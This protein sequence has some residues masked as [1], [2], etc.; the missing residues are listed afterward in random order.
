MTADRPKI[1]LALSGGS[2]RAI[3][4]IGVL[5]VFEE[6]GIPIDFLTACSSGA[7]I[8]ASFACGTIGDLKRDWLKLNRR[9]LIELLSLEKEGG[10][11]FNIDKFTNWFQRYTLGK[12][13]EDVKPAL[14]FVCVDIRT[15]EPI[16][17]N[18]GDIVR[19]SQASCTV[20]G[21]FEPVPWGNRLLVDGG[22]WSIV[23]T[24]QAKQMGADIVIGV[25]IA[26]T[27]YAFSRKLHQLRKGYRLVRDSLPLR[28]Y[29]KISGL[30]DRW[31][32][33]SLDF[34]YYNQS[35]I[36][37][38]SGSGRPGALAVFGKALDISLAQ[39]DSQAEVL[40]DCDY[41]ISPDIKHL[42]KADFE[43]SARMLEEGR[44]V[45]LAAIPEI[46]R[47]IHDH[48]K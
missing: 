11:I 25:D 41:L 9:F 10:G 20:P 1:G 5:E 38:E 27:R 46:K 35:D 22:L 21:L 14:G 12:K 16:V 37:E 45:T 24:S 4:H 34:I 13:F 43:H 31:F 18:L 47:L 39:W 7:L 32:T 3:A 36:L 2:G 26:S 30:L 29:G 33:K 40:T 17:L 15:G 23:P 48:V 19:A 8:A 28:I 42:G 6:Q 44:R